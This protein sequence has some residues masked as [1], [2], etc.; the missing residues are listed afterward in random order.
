MARASKNK[1]EVK[2]KKRRR[3]IVKYFREVIS[4]LKKVSWPSRKELIN[5]TIATIVFIVA[6]AI[7]VGVVDLILGQLLKLIS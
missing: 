7:V 5:S 4:E 3:S 6:F 1:P 2:T